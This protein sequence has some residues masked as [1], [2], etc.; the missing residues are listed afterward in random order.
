MT[1]YLTK[2]KENFSVECFVNRIEKD[3][4]QGK[5]F[6]LINGAKFGQDFFDEDLLNFFYRIE[7]N[8]NFLY[9]NDY[10]EYQ[11]TYEDLFAM[12]AKSIYQFIMCCRDEG[13]PE[14]QLRFKNILRL[15]N[16]ELVD[17]GVIFRAEYAFDHMFIAIVPFD[18][19]EKVIIKDNCQDKFQEVVLDRGDFYESLKE[20][21]AKLKVE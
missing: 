1:N 21:H 3:R 5:V 15:T 2:K 11:D 20:L 10:L 6:I 14:D 19:K 18:D 7:D 12:D 17:R 8:L 13:E 4:P 16:I 9:S